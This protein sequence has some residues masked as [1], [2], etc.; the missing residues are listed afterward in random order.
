MKHFIVGSVISCCLFNS[1]IAL[2]DDSTTKPAELVEPYVVLIPPGMKLVQVGDKGALCSPAIEDA[3]RQGLENVGPATR[4]STMPT[5]LLTRLASQRSSLIAEM[6]SDLNVPEDVSAAFIDGKLK[7][8]IQEMAAI[9]PRCYVFVGSE[10]EL[11][12]AEKAGWH[13]PLFYYNR[14]ADR[15]F[16]KPQVVIS[17]Q[18]KPDDIVVWSEPTPDNSPASVTDSVAKAMRQLD[19]GLQENISRSAMG[20]IDLVI[21]EFIAD[22]VARPLKL[23]TGEQWFGR[24]VIMAMGIKYTSEITGIWRASLQNELAAERGSHFILASQ[25]DLLNGFDP[26]S[27]KPEYLPY[28]DDAVSRKASRVIESLTAKAGDE[29]VGKI[30]TALKSGLPPDNLALVALITK[31]TGVDVTNDLLPQETLTQ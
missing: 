31:L 26:S 30:L 20:A 11:N 12:A 9:N 6:K 17:T 24:G 4:P 25:L 19:D 29:A 14:L 7:K 2:A 1:A 22:N 15:T 18:S 5:D 16:F 8:A 13:A 3:V 28:Y 10:D 23:P 21:Q 27:I